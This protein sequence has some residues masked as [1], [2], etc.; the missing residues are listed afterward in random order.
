MVDRAL[1]GSTR[2]ELSAS[3][4]NNHYDRLI[5]RHTSFDMRRADLLA[6]FAVDRKTRQRVSALAG[7]LYDTDALCSKLDIR[8]A[9]KED[10]LHAVEG[11]FTTV[12]PAERVPIRYEAF[13]MAIVEQTLKRRA[14]GLLS[15][16]EGVPLWSTFVVSQTTRERA[17]QRVESWFQ[18][19]YWK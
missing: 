9:L 12:P 14:P 15:R 7:I 19:S 10:V 3:A 18:T 6:R 2:T 11:F 1:P 4:Y 17:S 13:V 5:R 16:I 8:G